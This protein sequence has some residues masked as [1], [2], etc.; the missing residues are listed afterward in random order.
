MDAEREIRAEDAIAEQAERLSLLDCD[1]QTVHGQDIPR[2]RRNSRF[3]ADGVARD[4]HAL[5]HGEGVALGS[6][7]SA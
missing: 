6:R 2:G 4:H 7:R 5:D 1:A 3:R